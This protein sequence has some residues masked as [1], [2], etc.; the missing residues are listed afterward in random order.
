MSI[1]ILAI[2]GSL[3]SII[4][5]IIAILSTPWSLKNKIAILILI[6]IGIISTNYFILKSS[7][8]RVPPNI[9]IV[10]DIRDEHHNPIEKDSSPF[11]VYVK[12]TVSNAKDLFV[13]LVVCDFNYEWIQ[14]VE[15][16]GANI[17]KE[18]SGYCYLGII[19]DPNSINRWYKIFAIVTNK[20]YKEY[21]HPNRKSII[22]ESNKVDLYRTH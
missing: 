8:E 20:K 18:F 22:A 6:T 7:V 17:D 16:L 5:L 2:G 11:K 19:D 12:G 3:A 10:D 4:A 13:Y 21:E 9:T 14:P 1:T 15:C